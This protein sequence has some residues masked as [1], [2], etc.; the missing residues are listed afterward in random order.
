MPLAIT[1][2][3]G[4]NYLHSYAN[5]TTQ[6]QPVILPQQQPAYP[7]IVPGGQQT[8]IMGGGPPQLTFINVNVPTF[9][10][11]GTGGGG[12]KPVV[13]DVIREA[14]LDVI[15]EAALGGM[16]EWVCGPTGLKL[17]AVVDVD[18]RDVI[19]VVVS[20]PPAATAVVAEPTPLDS[21]VAASPSPSAAV[22][23][24]VAPTSPASAPASPGGTAIPPPTAS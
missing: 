9:G 6:P 8:W 23:I 12:G 7:A 16:L 15:A 3:N 4:V 17:I 22:T 10:T 21:P 20:A 11:P 24:P 5:P 14:R 2:S 18:G 19:P 13:S 1:Y